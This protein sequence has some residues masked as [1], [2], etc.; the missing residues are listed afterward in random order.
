MGLAVFILAPKHSYTIFLSKQNFYRALIINNAVLIQQT[1]CAALHSLF[2][3]WC[4]L[5]S[6]LVQYEGEGLCQTIS[7]TGFVVLI[8]LKGETY[9]VIFIPTQG[10]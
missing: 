6:L 4:I 5:V 10:L 8:A 7:P 1:G 3:F 9:K 2:V